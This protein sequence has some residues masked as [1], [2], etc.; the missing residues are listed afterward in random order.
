M[1]LIGF[2]DEVS[3]HQVGNTK[4]ISSTHSSP[5]SATFMRA[6]ISP[7]MEDEPLAQLPLGQRQQRDDREQQDRQR[8]AVA[9][10]MELEGLLVQ[11]VHQHGGRHA[12]PALRQ[13]RD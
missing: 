2:S 13:H 8:R 5:Y 6:E 4:G 3:I 1:S 11:V 10:A 9:E 12:G 7:F